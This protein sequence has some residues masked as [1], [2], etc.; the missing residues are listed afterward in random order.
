M[1]T[2]WGT[3]LYGWEWGDPTG[4]VVCAS[5]HV[6]PSIAVAPTSISPSVSAQ[7]AH[8]SSVLVASAHI[9]ASILTAALIIEE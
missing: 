6:A 7:S 9:S 4:A 5:I 8:T 1:A 2:G 3:S